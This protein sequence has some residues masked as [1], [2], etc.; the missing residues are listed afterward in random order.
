MAAAYECM[1]QM[2]D[3]ETFLFNVSLKDAAGD[4]PVWGD[5]AYEYALTGNGVTLLLTEGDGITIDEA[6]DLLVIGPTDR[7]YRLPAG[8]YS[9]GLRA[10]AVADD[11]TTQYFDGT[12]TVTEGNFA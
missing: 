1:I 10:T 11:T 2:T 6:S 12:V 8:T 5:Y 4:P 7:T 3:D 9:H